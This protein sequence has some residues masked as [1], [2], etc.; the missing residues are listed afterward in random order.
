MC[1]AWIARPGS[2]RLSGRTRKPCSTRSTP[3]WRRSWAFRSPHQRDIPE[4]VESGDPAGRDEAGR[5]VLL[6]DARPMVWRCERAAVDDPR[7]LPALLRPE[8]GAAGR[9]G[10]RNVGC[11]ARRGGGLGT[12][13]VGD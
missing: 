12:R 3:G 7:L 6:D 5:V 8:I 1:E 10:D 4:L 11:E 9:R 2:S 13:L